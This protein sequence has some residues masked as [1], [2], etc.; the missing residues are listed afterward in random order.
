[1]NKSEERFYVERAAEMLDVLWTV[2]E[3]REC[4]DYV[5][6][7]GD[8]QFGLEVSE[9]FI[10]HE[11]KKGA[12]KKAKESIHQ[13][14]IDCYREMYAT[15]KDIPLFIR[16]L[17]T[18]NDENMEELLLQ[19]FQHDF[20]SM[21]PGDQ[22]VFQ[23]NDQFKAYVTKALRPWWFRVDDRVGTVNVNP[24]PIIQKR[25]AMK[26]ARLTKY[27]EAIGED[28]RLL[29]VANRIMNSGKLKLVE[30]STI[31]TRGFQAVYFLSYPENVTVFPE[32]P[33]K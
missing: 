16:I 21:C 24:M 12:D 4:P 6:T 14:K 10:G 28:V 19:L 15:E 11:G 3:D 33:N 22:I 13:K 27:Q 8:H 7:E 25:V 23:P 18:V 2:G 1:M 30:K 31:D 32:H 17:G 20:E 26:S 29:L 9:L 5:V